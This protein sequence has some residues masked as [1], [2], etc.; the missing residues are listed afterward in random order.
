[1]L[2]ATRDLPVG[3]A[4]ARTDVAVRAVHESQLPSRALRG[5]TASRVVGRVVAVAVLRGTFLA[6]ENLAQRHRSGIDG[7][8][9][10]GM[11]AI[12]VV[13]SDALRPR[14]GAAVDV[15]ASFDARSLD[16]GADGRSASTVVVAAG[17]RVLGTDTR[18]GGGTGRGDP[19]GVTL[20]VDPAQAELLADAQANGVLT[21]A[22]VPPE[23]ASE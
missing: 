13:V 10:R 15:L 5:V 18:T 16:A 23:E 22:L 11:R 17:V 21:L 14:P 8:V 7:V 2:V 20:L 4:L 12:R 6:A 1:V 9:P 19:L 3:R